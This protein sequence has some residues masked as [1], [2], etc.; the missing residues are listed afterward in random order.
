MFCDRY[1]GIKKSSVHLLDLSSYS[2]D[3]MDCVE[4]RLMKATC[5]QPSANLCCRCNFNLKRTKLNSYLNDRFSVRE[6]CL[7]SFDS[8]ALLFYRRLVS[9]QT[10]SS[11]IPLVWNDHPMNRQSDRS[12]EQISRTIFWNVL[13]VDHL[14]VTGRPLIVF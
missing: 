6:P 1:V 12:Y 2:I 13:H 14:D 7:T 10:R 8:K 3:L 11:F 4:S 5:S 9:A